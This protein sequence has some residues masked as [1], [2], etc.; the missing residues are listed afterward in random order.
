MENKIPSHFIFR[1]N[2][3]REK[4]IKEIYKL[5]IQVQTSPSHFFLKPKL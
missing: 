3:Y 2:E 5:I 1:Q 4:K